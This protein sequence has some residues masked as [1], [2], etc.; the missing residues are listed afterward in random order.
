M[1]ERAKDAGPDASD[2]VTSCLVESA[3]HATEVVVK[4]CE[5]QPEQAADI[6]S[7]FLALRQAGFLG[8]IDE[9]GDAA[10]GRRADAPAHTDL[11][12]A[13]GPYRIVSKLGQGGQAEVFLA[14]DQLL[15]R[16]VAL[17]VLKD[18]GRVSDRE[19]RRF[20]REAEVASRL[21]HP[22]VCPVYDAGVHDGVAYI[23]MRYVAGESLATAIAET[24]EKREAASSGPRPV[25]LALEGPDSRDDVSGRG[26]RVPKS[27]GRGA[28][29][30]TRGEEIASVLHVLEKAARSLHAAHEA[31]IVHR[32]VKPGNIMVKP[33]GDPV[34]LDFGL[35]GE[36]EGGLAGLTRTGDVMGTPAYMSPEQLVGDPILLD[37]RTDVYSLGVSLY[38]CFT[39]ERPFDAP[40]R[41]ALHQ[42]IL[43]E[44][45]V[46]PRKLN[47]RISCDLTVVLETAME[48]DRTR[49]Y[50]TALDFAEDLRRVREHEPVAARPVS[51][52]GRLTRWSR[53]HPARAGLWAVLLIGLPG[54]AGLVGFLLATRPVVEREREREFRGQIELL[55][56]S[57]FDELGRWLLAA[58]SSTFDRV[59]SVWADNPAAIGGKALVLLRQTRCQE[60]L[61]LLQRERRTVASAPALRKLEVEALASLGRHAEATDVQSL[62]EP[63]TPIGYFVAAELLIDEIESAP[64]EATTRQALSYLLRAVLCA[65]KPRRLFHRR[66]GACAGF[67]PESTVARPIAWALVRN[68]PESA[69]SWSSAGTALRE[70]DGDAAIKAYETALALDP[71]ASSAMTGIGS[72]LYNRKKQPGKALAWFEKA[73][74]LRP[75]VAVNHFNAANALSALNR[76]DEAIDAY[77]TAIRLRTDF[78]SAY[79][80]LGNTYKKQR[81][82]DEAIS[83]YRKALEARKDFPEAYV[84]L[85]NAL[86]LKKQP[87]AAID[88]YESAI[89]V[90]PDYA[91]AH[92]QLGVTLAA[93]RRWTEAIA[94]YQRALDSDP[95]FAPGY[96][97]LGNAWADLGQWNKALQA[98]EKAVELAPGHARAHCNLGIA[99]LHLKR[100]DATINECKKAIQLKPDLYNA[101]HTLGIAQGRARRWSDAAKSFETAARLRPVEFDDRFNLAVSLVNAG[102]LDQAVKAYEKA[103]E[104]KPSFFRAHLYLG[105]ALR[106][107]RR[108]EEAA[109]A[110]RKVVELKDDHFIAWFQL[111]VA[112]KEGNRPTEAIEAYRRAIELN[113]DDPDTYFNLG[114]VLSQEAR[115]KEAAGAFQNVIARKPDFADAHA[116]L[117]AAL[118]KDR[119]LDDAIRAL[120]TAI[121]LNWRLHQAHDSLGS[122]L[123]ANEKPLQ[124]IASFKKAIELEPNSAG[125]RYNLANAL[126]RTGRYEEAIAAYQEAIRLRRN[127]TEARYNLGNTCVEIR[128]WE[129]AIEAYRTAI[130]ERPDLAYPRCNLGLV[131]REMG[132]YHDALQALREGHELG[133]RGGM[134]WTMPSAQWIEEVQRL[135]ELE[136]HVQDLVRGNKKSL[137][138]GDLAMCAEILFAKNNH[139]AAASLW[140]EAF[141]LD[142]DDVR[143]SAGHYRFRAVRAAVL[144][145]A[146]TVDA[147][148]ETE[149]AQAAEF[150]GF[151]L[152]RIR[153]ELALL[154][155]SKDRWNR[156]RTL[157]VWKWDPD[158]ASVREA[159][160]LAS[161]PAPEREAWSRFW[162]EVDARLADAR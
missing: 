104:L 135:I 153:E 12:E 59:R 5:D 68:W 159:R 155:R 91:L 119:R 1:Q 106:R 54:L 156:I 40:T 111:G 61:D 114:L 42:A 154:D 92:H 120:R 50:Q 39:L 36:M 66:L 69:S 49:R 152:V 147:Q 141:V 60:A 151:A 51:A 146:E 157:R 132:Q 2:L 63:R 100:V 65:P 96:Y 72:V 47:P 99:H 113:P 80:N 33:N 124:A 87:Q 105:E 15:R 84:A 82:L 9:A 44:D 129:E 136:G 122:A 103:A 93:L 89:R 142:S 48:K 121:K 19:M 130:E 62:V 29:A 137:D 83:A 18:S 34:W 25:E 88:A 35:A 46:D 26:R 109:A 110:Y 23:A 78:A 126:S 143:T 125:A 64:G 31:G 21:D 134:E 17:K 24:R 145:A 74:G 45:P 123:L 7:E 117:G 32:D 144:A 160:A 116:N 11:P 6:W 140:R 37:R 161:L 16:P 128:R 77:R 162:A 10:A 112:L 94:A 28:K 53:R 57:G 98:Y 115:W 52:V 30:T 8:P 4:A 56:E 148:A 70:V 102:R 85:G 81:R 138:A 20:A 67:L 38:E 133:T 90:K 22:G 118:L 86:R 107:L 13:I 3:R 127:F 75:S 73:I 43:T 71:N 149:R 95:G 108:W 14:E 101:Y 158:L 139:A 76:M 150:R 41:E 58:A 79:L 131:H 27:T 97:S 55:L